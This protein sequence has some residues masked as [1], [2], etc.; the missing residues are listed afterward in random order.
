MAIGPCW[1]EENVMTPSL[2]RRLVIAT[3]SAGV[4][5]GVLGTG[6]HAQAVKRVSVYDT[7][8]LA[9]AYT[10]LVEET[11]SLVTFEDAYYEY[12]G[13]L[14]D[15]RHEVHPSNPARNSPQTWFAPRRTLVFDYSMADAANPDVLFTN[16][17]SN[18]HLNFFDFEYRLVREGKWLHILPK[19]GKNARGESVQ[20]VSRLDLRVTFP[21]AERT[22][23]ATIALLVDTIN[24]TASPTTNILDGGGATNLFHRTKVRTGAQ[25]EIARHVLM[26]VLESTGRRVTW[27]LLCTFD[28]TPDRRTDISDG[29]C[30]L[31]FRILE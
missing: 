10:E 24:K 16:L 11:R 9:E 1:V 14:V 23:D 3:L 21:D 13:D 7:R 18:Y 28:P 5:A 17:V 6:A 26:R 19:A 27:S 31:N 8:P 29:A 30:G 25:N 4:A 2:I 22:A 20:R 12:K 15:Y